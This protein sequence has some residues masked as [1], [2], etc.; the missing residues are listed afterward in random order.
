MR[1]GGAQRI[2]RPPDW[3]P[4]GAPSWR[5]RDTSVLDDIDF[6]A[7]ALS[8]TSPSL[9]DSVPR[10]A[11]ESAVLVP[12]VETDGRAGVVLTRRADHLRNHSGEVSFPGGRM[13]E[14]ED[15]WEAALREAEEE[16]ALDRTLVTRVGELD[17]VLTRV[18]NSLIIPVVGRVAGSPDLVAH[19][20]EVARVFTVAF[21]DLV[22]EDTY[23]SETWGTPRGE[24]D[25]HFF[26]LDDETV[27]GATGRL[28]HAVI[29]RVTA[30]AQGPA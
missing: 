23:R 21:A 19:P 1:A 2:P 20:G 15:A 7:R 3:R 8:A 5:E 24:V 4:G 10:G 18:S 17:W 11:R 16:I 26:H 12:L 14:N 25:L 22:R 29:D 27:W 30:A 9:P 13:E 6:V 28:L